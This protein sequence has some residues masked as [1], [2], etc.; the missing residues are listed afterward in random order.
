MARMAYD[1]LE[2]RIAQDALGRQAGCRA[3]DRRERSL[4]RSAATVALADAARR[5][6]GDAMDV[7]V[8]VEVRVV[9]PYRV[10]EVPGGVVE[11]APE[12]G[13]GAHPAGELGLEALEVVA[14]RNG[15]GVEL[16]QRDDVQ[17][18]L[19]CFEVQKAGVEPAE[20][21]HADH[22]RTCSSFACD[23]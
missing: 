21:V 6:D 8:D 15:R 7:P 10:I 17:H 23:R 4:L 12:S 22:G 13:H 5:W 16:E 3:R 14:A 9:D 19:R 20:P 11:L 18:L 2:R 1:A